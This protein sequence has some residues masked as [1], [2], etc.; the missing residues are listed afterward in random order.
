M[1]A[2]LSKRL[3]AAGTAALRVSDAVLGGGEPAPRSR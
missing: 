1:T 2:I 3:E